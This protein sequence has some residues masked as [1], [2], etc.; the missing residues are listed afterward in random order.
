MNYRIS[1]ADD[2]L[3]LA[4]MRWD[5]HCEDQLTL[6]VESREQFLH[7]C[8]TFL[9]HGL[10][11]NAWT[12]WIAAQDTTI[13]AHIF[14]Y[15]FHPVPRPDRAVDHYGYMTNVYT[16]PAYRNRG[17][18]TFLLQSVIAGARMRDVAFLMVS[19][20][21]RSIPFYRRAGFVDQT[22]W[23]QLTLRGD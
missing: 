11:S 4:Q 7:T 8:L 3:Q 13:V 19:P 2:L 23:M 17:L 10:A 5:F 16:K 15:L 9:Q 12:Y 1:T 20:S 21:D 22:E 6:P 18:G 14:V